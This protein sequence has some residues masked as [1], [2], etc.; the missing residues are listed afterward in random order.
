MIRDA[1]QLTDTLPAT[2]SRRRVQLACWAAHHRVNRGEAVA[3]AYLLQRAEEA[4]VATPD[5]NGLILAVRTQAATLIGSDPGAIRRSL[6]ELLEFVRSTGDLSA[7]AASLLLSSRQAWVEGTVADVADVRDAIAKVATRMP[8]PD[9]Q[10]WPLA[11]DAAIELAIGHG[12]TAAVAI[13]HAA[14]IGRQLGVEVASSTALA[15]Q[16][17]LLFINGE[18]AA[19][20]DS[21]QG[22]A[23]AEDASPSLL[24]AFGLACAEAGRIDAVVDVAARML[25][26]PRL[27]TRAAMTWGQVAVG[28]SAVAFAAEDTALAESLWRSLAPYSGTGLALPGAGYFGTADRCLGLLAATVGDRQRAVELLASAASQE[29]RRGA[30]LWESRTTAELQAVRNAPVRF[31][32]VG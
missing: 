9:F 32:Q 24:A 15:Q 10:W 19:A 8:R 28:A 22:L 14:R 12:D 16:L 4:S 23:A 31:G 6:D 17:L 27:L 26:D 1:E 11:I 18:W 29:R 25:D 3:A 5:L 21:L 7:E 2:E 20:A 30:T 13:E